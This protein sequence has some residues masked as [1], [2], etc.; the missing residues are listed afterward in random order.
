[1][2]NND[3]ESLPH[4]L[5]MYDILTRV[6]IESVVRFTCVCKLWSKTLLNDKR[7]ALLHQ[8]NSPYSS[9]PGIIDSKLD[10][11]TCKYYISLFDVDKNKRKIIRFR[12][13]TNYYRLC[14]ME[15]KQH[16][17][18]LLLI[19]RRKYYHDYI[20]YNPITSRSVVLPLPVGG[21]LSDCELRL[22]YDPVGEKYK[23]VCFG[24]HAHE[25]FC[26]IL[27]LGEFG[28]HSWT[29]LVKPG[30]RFD[31]PYYYVVFSNGVLYWLRGCTEESMTVKK[32]ICSADVSTETLY[33]TD[34]P[35]DASFS[36]LSVDGNLVKMGG[37]SYIMNC[38]ASTNN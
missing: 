7:F 29:N 2:N 16:F 12:P 33:A 15:I 10:K 5:I 21:G 35:N 32:A 25:N 36:V 9:P 28:R 24:G 38:T 22:A 4:D 23:A 13:A 11:N 20:V 34:L 18:G 3:S 14:Y 19:H 6:P 30:F 17:N 27:T 37:S 31:K 26:K 8:K 1:M